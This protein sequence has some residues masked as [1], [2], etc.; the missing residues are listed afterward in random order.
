MFL[1]C[2][3]GCRQVRQVVLFHSRSRMRHHRSR[4]RHLHMTG[5]VRGCS[6]RMVRY[7]LMYMCNSRGC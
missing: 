6:G 2:G 4:V 3:R 5:T 1:L 7:W